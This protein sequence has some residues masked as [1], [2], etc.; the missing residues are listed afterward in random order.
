MPSSIPTIRRHF[1]GGLLALLAVALAGLA[2]LLA[3]AV[4]AEPSSARRLPPHP[5]SPRRA[6]GQP[7]SDLDTTADQVYGQADFNH[8]DAPNPPTAASLN[9]PA[10][11]N[12]YA[13]LQVFVA[14]TGNNRVLIWND[15]DSYQDGDP[16]DV[17]L[18]QPDFV[19]NAALNPPTASSLN[20]PW[21]LDFDDQGNLYVSDTGN[22]RV[23]VFKP[24]NV[25]D[26]GF[27]TFAKDQQASMVIGQPNFTSDAAPNPPTGASLDHPMGI[28]L[29]YDDNLVVADSDNNRVLIFQTPLQTG[30]SAG[31][32]LG[33][34]R[35]V[36]GAPEGTYGDFTA[37]AAPNPPTD[38]SLNHP[39]GVAIGAAHNEL[40]VA[41]TGN[42]RVL[43]YTAQPAVAVAVYVIGQPDFTSNTPNNGGVSASS[44]DGPTGLTIDA[45]D[46]LLLADTGNNRVLEYD[47]PLASQAANLVF[48]QGGSFTTNSSN[49][50]GVSADSLDAPAGVASD[51]DW[52]DVYIADQGNNRGLE[53]DQPLANAVPEVVE[54]YPGTVRA[55][56]PGFELDILGTGIISGTE[57]QVNGVPLPPAEPEYLGEVTTTISAAE[58]ATAGT[59]PIKLINPPPGGGPSQPMTLTVY[60]PRAGDTT[61]D[62]VMGQPG[63]TNDEGE[64]DEVGA[65]T[66][67]GPTGIAVDRSTGRVFVLDKQDWRVLSW[68]SQSALQDGQPADLVIGQPD[69]EEPD[70]DNTSVTGST[71]LYPTGIAVDNNGDLYVADTATYRVLVFRAPLSNGMAASVVIG[72]PDFTTGTQPT[73]PTASNLLLPRGV[74]TDSAGNLYVADTNDNR[75]LEFAAPLTT[76]EAASRVF[77]QGGSFT[78]NGANQGGLSASTLWSPTG[79]AL[80]ASNRLYVADSGNNRVLEYDAPLSGDSTADRVFG[81]GGSF[82]T[83]DPNKGGVS[84]D[85]L[86][87]PTGMAL[88]A[89]GALYIA[90]E[91]DHRVL[92]Y[93]APLSGDTAADRVFGQHG[94]FTANSPDNGGL[95]A[96]TLASPWGV[97]VDAAGDLYV[98]DSANNRAL[99]YLRPITTSLYLPIV[100]KN[101]G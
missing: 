41:D 42:N 13:S 88:S 40:Y 73:S 58:I 10:G 74:A 27:L 66:L 15:L 87:W 45:G 71:L 9:A 22:N 59:I 19:T 94:S 90:D 55:G 16:A 99:V 89:D 93:N 39:T 30:M 85:S 80:D 56:N 28:V 75:V 69:F 57:V 70:W 34:P 14:D 4:R 38:T 7:G 11:M 63:F 23:L 35:D 26:D 92:E 52:L 37:N 83:Q 29:D 43:I 8:T 91:N 54:L 44:L 95:S 36:V 65:D 77:G 78:T 50:G 46:R 3:P 64:F 61:A 100:T 25:G 33:Q 32:V 82:D 47:H 86:D 72:Q 21:A 5:A 6:S 17:V 76:G 97:A 18:G 60:A 79:V 53:Y 81:Q 24:T 12:V 1:R 20:S 101:Q 48:G 68:P 51:D 2:L 49:E 62:S 31:K 67:N 98:A 84:A 96:D